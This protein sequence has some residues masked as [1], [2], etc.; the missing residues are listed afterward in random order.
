MIVKTRKIS[1]KACQ[2]KHLQPCTHIRILN[3]RKRSTLRA[4]FCFSETLDNWVLAIFYK[5]WWL[6]HDNKSVLELSLSKEIQQDVVHRKITSLTKQLLNSII[7]YMMQRPWKSASS[8]L[9]IW[10]LNPFVWLLCKAA[11]ANTLCSWTLNIKT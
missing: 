8:V 2:Y 1:P 9:Y 10:S 6:W 5:C 11:G 3:S 7:F 4:R